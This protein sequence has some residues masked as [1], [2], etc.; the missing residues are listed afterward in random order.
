[1]TL[2]TMPVNDNPSNDET[3]PRYAIGGAVDQDTLPADVQPNGDYRTAIYLS[4]RV[5]RLSDRAALCE[6][7]DVFRGSTWLPLSWLRPSTAIPT[8]GN[9]YRFAIPIHQWSEKRAAL[10]SLTSL[11]RRDRD[12]GPHDAA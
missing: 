1:M 12:A 10:L 7:P 6:T 11:R 3:D 8:R 2:L 4:L 5:T 9:V